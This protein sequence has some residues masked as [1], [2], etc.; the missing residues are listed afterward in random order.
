MTQAFTE[1]FWAFL[2]CK[3]VISFL[4]LRLPVTWILFI[5]LILQKQKKPPN[6]PIFLFYI[7]AT[8]VKEDV[9][10]F[11][12]SSLNYTYCAVKKYQEFFWMEN[13]LL[14]F[15]CQFSRRSLENEKIQLG[16]WHFTPFPMNQHFQWVSF[17]MKA[18]CSNVRRK[19]KALL[20]KSW[21][22]SF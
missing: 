7:S 12:Q 18:C 3:N 1:K 10:I 17:D 14:F 9:W 20:L 4:K 5:K 6:W 8:V 16:V 15:F 13:L 2:N 22:R 21:L 19:I 11:S